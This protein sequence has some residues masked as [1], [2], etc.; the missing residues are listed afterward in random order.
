MKRSS[1]K[2]KTPLRAK[3]TLKTR[4][5]IGLQGSKTPL[6]RAKVS[7]TSK[8]PRQR[9]KELKTQIIES[10]GLPNIV[11]KR[12]GTK[13]KATRMEI[14]KGMLWAVFSE[15]I[16]R[17][18]EG[19][20]ISCGRYKTYEELQAGHY[21]PMG[22]NDI[23]LGFSEINVNGECGGCNGFDSF[24]LIPMRKNLILKYGEDTIDEID[25]LKDMKRCIVWSEM[26]IALKIKYYYNKNA[27]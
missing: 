4:S 21:V 12:Y 16:R 7:K 24:H 15:Y 5:T 8:T 26:E 10:Y 13:A 20:C 23:E 19:M 11:P 22:G 1:L 25:R 27:N 3:T 17:R 2:R 6:E 18:D 14:L 9:K